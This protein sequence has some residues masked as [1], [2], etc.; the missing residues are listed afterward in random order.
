MTQGLILKDNESGFIIELSTLNEILGKNIKIIIPETDGTMALAKDIENVVNRIKNGDIVAKTADQI[1]QL[2]E[3]DIAKADFSNIDVSAVS[4]EVFSALQGPQGPQ[5]EV[6]DIGT[7]IY[8]GT[9]APTSGTSGRNGIDKYLDKN[10]GI[11]YTKTSAGSWSQEI[12]LMGPQ[13]PQGPA[14]ADGRDGQDAD[15][16]AVDLFN[17][18]SN[19]TV[20]SGNVTAISDSRYVEAAFSDVTMNQFIYQGKDGGSAQIDIWTQGVRVGES[21]STVEGRVYLNGTRIITVPKTGYNNNG[22]LQTSAKVSITL[23]KG[24]VIK[25]TGSS[26]SANIGMRLYAADVLSRLL[27]AY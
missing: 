1:G 6:G 13:G 24:D 21:Y 19:T 18:I 23:N 12:N 11:L 22:A 10:T 16:G 14:G 17:V 20:V 15:I 9:G 25:V 27:F 2:T 5:G 4:P 8:S 3:D 26:G 7:I